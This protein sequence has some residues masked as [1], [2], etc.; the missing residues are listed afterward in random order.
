MVNLLDLSNGQ[1]KE[2]LVLIPKSVQRLEIVSSLV[3]MQNTR[4]QLSV[5][6]ARTAYELQVWQNREVRGLFGTSW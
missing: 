6:Y 2:I 4:M 1:C 3:S 5:R